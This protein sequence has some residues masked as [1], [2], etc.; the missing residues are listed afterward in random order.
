MEDGRHSASFWSVTEQKADKTLSG[1]GLRMILHVEQNLFMKKKEQRY[2]KC[3][4]FSNS[5][6]SNI[7]FPVNVFFSA[8]EMSNHL[9]VTI[10]VE[11]LSVCE[12]CTFY[13]TF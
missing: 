1:T 5:R 13:C 4:D 2:A 12:N 10:Q 9:W 7:N 8:E 3:I 6:E 11:Y